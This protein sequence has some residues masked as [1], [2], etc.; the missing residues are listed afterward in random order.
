MREIN[1]TCSR[2]HGDKDKRKGDMKI[3]GHQVHNYSITHNNNYS[4][5]HLDREKYRQLGKPIIKPKNQPMWY[6]ACTPKANRLSHVMSLRNHKIEK[7][8]MRTTTVEFKRRILQRH[9][10]DS[11]GSGPALFIASHRLGD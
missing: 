11:C 2:A 8:V 6:I 4:D 9:S 5:S 10:P 1:D 3:L 7:T